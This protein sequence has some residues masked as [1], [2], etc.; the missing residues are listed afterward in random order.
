M[1]PE[2]VSNCKFG[3]RTVNS[4]MQNIFFDSCFLLAYTEVH[5][6]KYIIIIHITIVSNTLDVQ[7]FP[8]FKDSK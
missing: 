5:V 6:T 7:G 3:S 2:N 1:L 8:N 4:D